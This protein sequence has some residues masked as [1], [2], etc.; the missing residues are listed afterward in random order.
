MAWR[1]LQIGSV[2]SFDDHFGQ[3]KPRYGKLRDHRPIRHGNLFAI[4]LCVNVP[5]KIGRRIFLKTP[6]AY[7]HG[8]AVTER[9]HAGHRERV[10]SSY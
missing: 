6:R 2:V 10:L 4:H 9:Q 7:E 8:C 3:A 5:R 1:Q